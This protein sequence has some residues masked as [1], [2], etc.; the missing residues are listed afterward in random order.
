M[1][2]EADRRIDIK[3]NSQRKEQTEGRTDRT[4]EVRTEI[5]MNRQKEEQTIG[6]VYFK[7]L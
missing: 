3:K 6:D 7:S 2:D 5:R 4:N 1:V